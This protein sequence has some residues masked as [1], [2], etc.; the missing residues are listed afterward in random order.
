M[1]IVIHEMRLICRLSLGKRVSSGEKLTIGAAGLSAVFLLLIIRD[2]RWTLGCLS[3]PTVVGVSTTVAFLAF[4]DVLAES[5][6]GNSSPTS[7]PA[8]T[9]K[10]SP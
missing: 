4:E 10:P 6:P 8:S 2:V 5:E 7:A 1:T 3:F 9:L